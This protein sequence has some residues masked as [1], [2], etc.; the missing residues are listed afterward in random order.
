MTLEKRI[1]GSK[2]KMKEVKTSVQF[3][4]TEYSIKLIDEFC[5]DNS[6]DHGKIDELCKRGSCTSNNIYVALRKFEKY[7][8]LEVLCTKPLR[9]RLK[10]E[11]FDILINKL[12]PFKRIDSGASVISLDMKQ[13]MESLSTI[14]KYLYVYCDIY[15][16][17]IA[18]L[19]K[20]DSDTSNT[21]G[22]SNKNLE[23]SIHK[24]QSAVSKALTKLE[25]LKIVVKGKHGS[26]LNSHTVEQHLKIFESL[27][28]FNFNNPIRIRNPKT[29]RFDY[30]DSN[31]NKVKRVQLVKTGPI[32]DFE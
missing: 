15:Y 20:G 24:S 5:K 2:T 27:S 31:G 1:D 4:L 6:I 3:L 18:E 25:D 29:K 28:D 16:S 26:L 7:G 23:I 30:I 17:I 11:V 10:Q 12:A 13:S 9:A 32:G 22:I 14:K 21:D 19:S 8:F